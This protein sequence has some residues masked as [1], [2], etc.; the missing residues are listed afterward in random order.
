MKFSII[1]IMYQ[2]FILLLVPII[3]NKLFGSIKNILI[4]NFVILLINFIINYENLL[5]VLKKAGLDVLW[6]DN[7]SGCKGVCARIP[8]ENQE[9]IKGDINWFWFFT[10]IDVSTDHII[11]WNL[12]F[13]WK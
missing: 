6:V 1:N 4:I 13:T 10:S 7:Q 3:I 9:I 11:I 8:A 12:I 2:I 5:D